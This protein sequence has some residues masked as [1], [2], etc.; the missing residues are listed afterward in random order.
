MLCIRPTTTSRNESTKRHTNIP[1]IYPSSQSNQ[2]QQ[3]RTCLDSRIR[4]NHEPDTFHT[5]MIPRLHQS[6]FD[7]SLD[8]NC[9]P[10]LAYIPEKPIIHLSLRHTFLPL[11]LR[12]A[13]SRAQTPTSV[14]DVTALRFSMAKLCAHVGLHRIITRRREIISPASEHYIIRKKACSLMLNSSVTHGK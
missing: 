14:R 13:H 10:R 5:R 8:W 11:K 3:A 9:T 1:Q 2:R 7:C 4:V 6:K 12:A